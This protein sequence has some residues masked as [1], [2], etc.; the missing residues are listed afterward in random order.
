MKRLSFLIGLCSLLWLTGCRE[1]LSYPEGPP[2]LETRDVVAGDAGG[3]GQDALQG[4]GLRVVQ[5]PTM[6]YVGLAFY[7]PV[8]IEV[9]NPGLDTDV[10]IQLSVEDGAGELA[11]TT[12]VAVVEGQAIFE[13]V[14]YSALQQELILVARRGEARVELDPFDVG[15]PPPMV[16]ETVN[17]QQVAALREKPVYEKNRMASDMAG[18]ALKQTQLL[19]LQER[20]DWSPDRIADEARRRVF[21]P[22]RPAWPEKDVRNKRG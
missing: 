22:D 10:E 7:P 12:R 18:F 17:W 20:P 4:L 8:I 21:R 11:G 1:V 9:I 19:L 14:S 3:P 15:E 16:T 13:G 2:D 5:Q 6:G